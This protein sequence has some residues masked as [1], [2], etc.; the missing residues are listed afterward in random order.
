MFSDPTFWVLVSFVI[1][2][3]LI[4]KKA[5]TFVLD[6]LDKRSNR[7]K[8]KLDE[9]EKLREEAQSMLATYKRKQKDAM[10]EAEAI[11]EHAREQSR[12][13]AEQAAKDLEAQLARR[14]AQ[15]NDRIAQ[16]EA[17]ALADVRGVAAD[18]A[19]LATRELLSVKLT[20]K[21]SG[22][23]IDN[24]VEELPNRLH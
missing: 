5:G 3:V 23:L 11:L 15:I 18:I 19:I 24:A 21:Q 13:N 16:A 2:F 12:A 1:F 7:I 20:D 9:A 4:G 22:A 10:K 17:Q 14:E 8:S 6:G